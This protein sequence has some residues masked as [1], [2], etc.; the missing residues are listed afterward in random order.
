MRAIGALLQRAPSLSK[1]RVLICPARNDKRFGGVQA[2]EVPIASGG[3][4]RF[5]GDGSFFKMICSIIP[6]DGDPLG[7]RHGFVQLGTL[8]PSPSQAMVKHELWMDRW[9][10][11]Y[12]EGCEHMPH[13]PTPP[14]YTQESVKAIE[15][16]FGLLGDH[17]GIAGGA[18]RRVYLAL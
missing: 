6:R 15:A 14:S 9:I 11:R 3:I 2:A 10:D 13:H 7:K 4:T 1:V 18:E 16:V 12:V 8:L 17:G 5:C